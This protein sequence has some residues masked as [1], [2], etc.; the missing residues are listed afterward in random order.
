MQHTDIFAEG[1]RFL[2]DTMELTTGRLIVVVR[3]CQRVPPLALTARVVHQRR[4]MRACASDSDGV[5]VCA[6]QVDATVWELYGDQMRTWAESVDLKL[7]A[8][9]ARANEDHKTLET[10]TYMLDELKRADPLRRSEPVLAVGT[11]PLPP[12]ASPSLVLSCT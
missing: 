12:R 9:V 8:I 5:C 10:F 3:L 11:L 1:N 4:G 6:V 2:K 7:D